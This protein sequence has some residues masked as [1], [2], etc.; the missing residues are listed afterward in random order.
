MV[1]APTETAQALDDEVFTLVVSSLGRC[2]EPRID[3]AAAVVWTGRKLLE[4]MGFGPEVFDC[5]ECGEPL[6]AEK[7]RF[8]PEAGGFLCGQC[9]GRDG[10]LCSVPTMKMMRVAA[11]GDEKTFFSVKLDGGMRKELLQVLCAEVE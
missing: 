10:I 5:V 11:R 1:A 7:T 6:T 9:A 3:P 8:E 2:R 4:R